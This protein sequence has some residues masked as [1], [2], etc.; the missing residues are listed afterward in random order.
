MISTLRQT[1]QASNSPT[2]FS[3]IAQDTFSHIPKSEL[4]NFIDDTLN[5]SRTF[6][7]HL[8]TQ[9]RMYDALRSKRLIMKVSKSHFL[10]DSMRVLGH[11]FSEHGRIPDNDIATPTDTT[12]IRSFLGLVNF[13]QD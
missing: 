3:Q 1:P 10:Y 11:I 12:G 2:F 8:V 13:N 6:D 4:I 7:Q 5:H 9:Q